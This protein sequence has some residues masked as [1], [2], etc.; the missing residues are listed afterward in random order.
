MG[1]DDLA[2]D[3]NLL[4]ASKWQRFKSWLWRCKNHKRVVVWTREEEDE[5]QE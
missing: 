5:A 3:E 2:F 1:R 4:K